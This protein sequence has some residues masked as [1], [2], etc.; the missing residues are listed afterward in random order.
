MV[1]NLFA[2]SVHL[3]FPHLFTVPV[4]FLDQAGGAAE[5][6][7]FGVGDAGVLDHI[8][9]GQQF[10]IKVVV[11]ALPLVDHV[12]VVI[13]Q[14]NTFGILRRDQHIAVRGAR[15]VLK[16]AERTVESFVRRGRRGKSG[17]EPGGSQSGDDTFH[18]SLQKICE[19]CGALSHLDKPDGAPQQCPSDFRR[20]ISPHS[21]QSIFL[22][23]ITQT[24]S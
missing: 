21:F 15:I 19:Q 5:H 11:L 13:D 14:I 4:E 1:G 18:N 24:T 23:F 8:A 17:D 20:S 16:H 12:A 22:F 6:A 7:G 3:V 2:G 10:R 9:V